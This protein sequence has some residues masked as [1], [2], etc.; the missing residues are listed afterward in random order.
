MNGP[1]LVDEY[2]SELDIDF[3][4]SGMLVKSDTGMGATHF[5]LV[6]PRNSI[7]VEPI[8]VTACNKV[9][10]AMQRNDYPQDRIPFYVGSALGDMLS[11][12]DDDILE[13][14]NEV[15]FK[16]K[17]L[18]CVADSLPRVMRVIA[19]HEL[20]NAVDFFLLIDEVDSIQMDSSFRKAMEVCLDFYQY[21][22]SD[23]RAMLT[24]TPLEFS[25]PLLASEPITR[26]DLRST[27]PKPT[28]FVKTPN[29][30]Q[31]IV[32]RVAELTEVDDSK[33]VIVLNH[34]HSIHLL[35]EAFVQLGI[36][37]KDVAVLCSSL[38]K[39][40]FPQHHREL[41]S[42]MYPSRINF[43][44]SAYYSGYDINE[45]F[46]LIC[47]ANFLIKST[48]LSPS[49]I[50][51]IHGR[52]RKPNMILSH[53][54]V[55]RPQYE[56]EPTTFVEL[57]SEGL[58]SEAQAIV[59]SERC[60]NIHYPEGSINNLGILKNF[61]AI[62]VDALNAKNL[63]SVRL[64]SEKSKLVISY[65]FIDSKVE[66]YNIYNTFYSTT[67]NP[68]ERLEET[69]F[70]VTSV[71]YYNENV[72][73]ATENQQINIKKSRLV[74]RLKTLVELPE[75]EIA[76]ELRKMEG[77]FASTIN[78]RVLSFMNELKYYFPL[79]DVITE[80]LNALVGSDG[81]PRR[82]LRAFN[83]WLV[84]KYFQTADENTPIR[85]FV[86]HYFKKGEM[87]SST[88]VAEYMKDCI[89]H[90]QLKTLLGFDSRVP[91]SVNGN[92]KLLVTLAARFVNLCRKRRRGGDL[93]YVVGVIPPQ[94]P[95]VLDD[96]ELSPNEMFMDHASIDS[97]FD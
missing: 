44:T 8:R 1:F 42:D 46:H 97:T 77:V 69:G 25:N 95:R 23:K 75:D 86:N 10:S 37:T 24:A 45:S 58:K 3:L 40:E 70:D 22:P 6:S 33:I 96:I 13:Y 18:I 52:C 61:R 89:V 49:Q 21:Q 71:N 15:Q 82:D 47:Y 55:Y 93:F 85:V 76:D 90:S 56:K 50:K 11:P 65:F 35:I 36:N 83:Y 41:T 74:D 66:Q 17:K 20:Y 68:V 79:K 9:R 19:N 62:L 16:F 29:G 94:T 26:F 54:L 92:S 80:A 84:G 31:Y 63:N 91:I 57:T 30:L 27:T 7:I 81:L 87:L 14:L 67:A 72:I 39:D 73:K 43:I 60:F 2:I 12:K 38:S 88:Q 48:M 5:E 78:G 59:D 53:S 32:D 34:M 51:Q 4:P 28:T 64:N